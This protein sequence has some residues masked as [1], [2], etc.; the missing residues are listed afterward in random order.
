MCLPRAPPTLYHFDA[1][2]DYAVPVV[3]LLLANCSRIVERYRAVDAVSVT[4]VTEERAMARILAYSQLSTR[5]LPRKS[6]VAEL[7]AR[8]ARLPAFQSGDA[9]ICGSVCW[10]AHAPSSDVDVAYVATEA[11][12]RIDED[13]REARVAYRSEH[14]SNRP[15]SVP[16]VDIILVGT[17]ALADSGTTQGLSAVALSATA[18][19]QTV[20][21]GRPFADVALRFADHIGAIAR[22]RGDPW[23]TFLQRHLASLHDDSPLRVE[24]IRAFVETVCVTWE[25]GPL[26]RGER[27]AQGQFTAHQCD[28]LSQVSGFNLHLMRRMLGERGSYPSPDRASDILDAFSQID[29]PWAR[30]ILAAQPAFDGLVDAYHEMAGELQGDAAPHSWT[31][32]AFQARLEELAMS[33][34]LQPIRE[35][36]WSYLSSRT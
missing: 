12:P 30:P 26:R 20:D 1:A 22:M 24:G 6:D 2:W 14:G 32:E 27:D 15:L 33:L 36:V 17:T 7:A 25:D 8:I 21:A 3:N 16:R 11:F 4:M 18:E 23:R 34:P 9:V 19:A 31:S 10:N 29:E 5:T 28:L 35:A 13:I